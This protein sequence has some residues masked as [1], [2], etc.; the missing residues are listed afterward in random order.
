MSAHLPDTNALLRRAVSITKAARG[1]GLEVLDVRCVW[2]QGGERRLQVM[3][4]LRPDPEDG[5]AYLFEPPQ[6]GD[7]AA[8][9][10][11]AE[12]ATR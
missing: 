4:G 12:A 6:D 1:M 2:P 5:R 9:R 8:L 10:D 11:V 7:E 3:F